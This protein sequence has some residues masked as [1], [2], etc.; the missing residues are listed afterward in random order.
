MAK[1]MKKIGRFGRVIL[2]SSSAIALALIVFAILK[3]IYSYP[4]YKYY[5][6]PTTIEVHEPHEKYKPS[7]STSGG[8]FIAAS[9]GLNHWKIFEWLNA[10]TGWGKTPDDYMEIGLRVQTLRQMF[11][12]KHGIQPAQ[13][14]A[15]DRMSGNPPLQE[16]PLEGVTL[17][18]EGMSQEYWKACGWDP[19]TGIP[20]EETIARLQLNFI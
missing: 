9:T 19:K 4:I 5:N 11:N 1:I 2:F 13:V 20:T 10:A 15:H 16:G 18:I 3:S 17:N 8:C 14:K 6:P 12:V 7:A